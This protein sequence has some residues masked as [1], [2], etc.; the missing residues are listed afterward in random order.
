MDRWRVIILL[1]LKTSVSLFSVKKVDV[2]FLFHDVSTIEVLYGTLK[3]TVA[4][5]LRK[6][7]GLFAKQ[8]V[9]GGNISL[10][11]QEQFMLPKVNI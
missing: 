5:K 4:S 10:F 11:D 9:W 1:F 7:P 2:P 3:V 6:L 8:M